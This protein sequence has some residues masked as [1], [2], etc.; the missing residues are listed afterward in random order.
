ML[1]SIIGFL[2]SSWDLLV[3]T[4]E[5]LLM[6]CFFVSNSISVTL[7]LVGFLPAIIGTA[8]LITIAV[9]VVRFLLLK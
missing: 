7:S 1:N 3:N 6:A 2:Q 9:F 5:T 4:I 8:L